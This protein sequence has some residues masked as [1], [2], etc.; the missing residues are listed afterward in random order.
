MPNKLFKVVIMDGEK[1]IITAYSFNPESAIHDWNWGIKAYP[2]KDISCT[3]DYGKS[4]SRRE[5]TDLI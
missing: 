4:Y 2:G 5:L 1:V 3:D